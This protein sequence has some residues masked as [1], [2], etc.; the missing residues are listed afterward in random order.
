MRRYL[1][2]TLRR[3]SSSRTIRSKR[4]KRGH[5]P[6]WVEPNRLTTQTVQRNFGKSS[7]NQKRPCSSLVSIALFSGRPTTDEQQEVQSSGSRLRCTP[8]QVAAV[9]LKTVAKQHYLPPLLFWRFARRTSW[10]RRYG[11]QRLFDAR[12]MRAAPLS[13][14]EGTFG[15]EAQDVDQKSKN[16]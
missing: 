6:C 4:P 7:N 3:L 10:P 14:I 15:R 1:G 12:G 5:G 2:P 9:W 16:P 8:I 11:V 13:S